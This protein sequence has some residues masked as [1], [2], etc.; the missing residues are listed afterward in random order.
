L[1]GASSSSSSPLSQVSHICLV[2]KAS[3]VYHTS[4]ANISH[5]DED[6]VHEEE[7]ELIASLHDKGEVVHRSL[8][9]SE[10]ACSK[11]VEILIFAIESQKLIEM[12]ENTILKM[13]ALELEYADEIGSL[14]DELEEEETT[15]ESLEETFSLEIV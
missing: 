9:K 5:N 15:K 12:H 4:E 1:N 3:T 6:E 13:G 7:E 2:A 11:F 10:I 8:C 14:K